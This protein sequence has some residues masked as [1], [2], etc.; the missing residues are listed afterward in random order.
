MYSIQ[1]LT[2]FYFF[3]LF[4][5]L[6]ALGLHCYAWAFSSFSKQRLL[7]SCNAQ[8]SHCNDFSCCR[9]RALGEQVSVVVAR[10]LQSTGSVVVAIGFVAP[11]HVGSSQTRD[12]TC[13]PYMG[14][15]LLTLNHLGS[16]RWYLL[17]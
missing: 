8:A 7:S 12:Q 15:R 6:A 17:K 13:V 11:Q 5:F 9:A 4:L 1:S 14:S 2:I 3:N 10:G 16:P